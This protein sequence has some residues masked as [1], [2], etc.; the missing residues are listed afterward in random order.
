M[1][2]SLDVLRARLRAA[3]ARIAAGDAERSAGAD[4]RARAIAD[5]VKRR[6]RGGANSLAQELGVTNSAISNAVVRARGI[7]AAGH[8]R[9]PMDTLE[10]LLA[11]EADELAP[12]PASWWAVL[13]WIVRSTFIDET[14]LHDPAAL[15][16]DEVED[17]DDVPDSIGA[18]ALASVCRSW[19]RTQ[20]LAVIDACLRGEAAALPTISDEA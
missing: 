9:L 19:N 13:E 1:E 5:E 17:T 15:L 7:D 12:L 3:D 20:A 11:L 14:W 2:S 18:A 4:D 16:A 8:R 6:G 10:R